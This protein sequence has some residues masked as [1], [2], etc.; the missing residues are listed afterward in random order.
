M[1]RLIPSRHTITRPRGD[2]SAQPAQGDALARDRTAAARAARAASGRGGLGVPATAHPLVA[3]GEWAELARPGA[4]LDWVAFD[5]ARGPGSRPDP[6]YG[7]ALS[8]VREN[9]VPLLGLLDVAYGARPF[10]ELITDASSYLNWYRVDGF[11]LSRAPVLRARVDACRRVVTT[12]RALLAGAGKAGEAGKGGGERGRGAAPEAGAA[13]RR[14][15]VLAPGSHPYPGY[16]EFADQIVTFNGPW[17]RYRWSEPPQW[18]ADHPPSRFAHLV[19][20]LPSTHLDTAL[21]IARWQGAGTVCLTDRT[22]REGT[23]PWAGL[24]RYWQEAVRKIR[25]QP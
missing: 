18:T 10:G 7:E 9:G 25:R 21:R 3:P 12:L 4:P 24:P 13:A 20:S 2:R 19:H 5:V 6:L 16:A 17:S 23:D 11:F 15:V 1:P 22:D 14:P 8:L